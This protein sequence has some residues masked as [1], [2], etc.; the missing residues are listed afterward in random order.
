[1]MKAPVV[2]A[3]IAVGFIPSSLTAVKPEDAVS[4]DST[5]VP[6]RSGNIV[7]KVPDYTEARARVLRLARARKAVLLEEQSQVNL[8]GERHGNMVLEMDA[9]QLTPMMENVRRVGKLYSERAQTSDLTSD[10]QSLGKRISL[11][12]QNET[13]LLGFLRSPRRMRGSDILFVQYRLYESRVQAA[14]ASQQQAD[15]ARRSRRGTL[16]VMLFEPEPRKTFDWGNWRSLASY[17]AKGSFLYV[18]RKAITGLFYV[19]YFAPY[20]VPA[21]LIAFFGGRRLIRWARRRMNEWLDR[22]HP[23]TPPA[24]Q[25]S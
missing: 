16:D 3:L 5:R 6:V 10:Y 14:N 4:G 1:M 18:T 2:L 25:D 19:A 8:P 9:A 20:W 17:R 22:G 23:A 7:L 24:E 21:L 13:E 15:I 12:D 11:L